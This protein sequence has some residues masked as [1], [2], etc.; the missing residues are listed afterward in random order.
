[1]GEYRYYICKKCSNLVVSIKNSAGKMICCGEPM[2]RLKNDAMEASW[3]KNIPVFTYENG[4][5][6][7]GVDSSILPM[8]EEYSTKWIF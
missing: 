5:A 8:I 7:L 1:M 6:K 4:V 2:N 3:Q